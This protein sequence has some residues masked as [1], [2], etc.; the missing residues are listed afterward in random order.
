MYPTRTQILAAFTWDFRVELE[1]HLCNAFHGYGDRFDPI[2]C[3]G[4]YVPDIN[5]QCKKQP[6]KVF[7]TAWFGNGGQERYK[8]TIKL[9]KKA[10][11]WCSEGLSLSDCLMPDDRLDWVYLDEEKKEIVVSLR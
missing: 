5:G 9:G 2:G 11:K 7:T 1:Y 6:F 10:R 8:M 3:D 4:V